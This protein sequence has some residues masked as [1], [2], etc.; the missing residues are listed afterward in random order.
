MTHLRLATL[1]TLA[2]LTLTGPASCTSLDAVRLQPETVEVAPGL[3]PVAG[4]Q[5]SATSLYLLFIGIP[6]V[7]LDKVVNQMLVV[8]AKTMGADKVAGLS[9]EIDPANGVWA[10]WRLLG[11]RS[12]RARG[13]AVQVV[14]P[15]P[16]T[17]ADEG[18]EAGAPPTEPPPATP[19]PPTA[20]A[21]R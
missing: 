1:A 13:I 11:W 2:G 15:P 18:P 10:L 12:A 17:R 4:I 21:P 5:A 16:D 7:S 8:A 6:G 9:F 20:P 19:P 3:R 14:A